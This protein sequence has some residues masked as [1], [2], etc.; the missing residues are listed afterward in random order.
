L[1]ANE[2]GIGVGRVHVCEN[3]LDSFGNCMMCQYER[4]V[5]DVDVHDES[6]LFVYDS[7]NCGVPGCCD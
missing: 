1:Y 5:F 7:D 4:L 6:D 2:I 3:Y